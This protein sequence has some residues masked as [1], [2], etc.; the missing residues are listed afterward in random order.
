M[1][2]VIKMGVVDVDVRILGHLKEELATLGPQINCFGLLVLY[3]DLKNRK[4]T[5]RN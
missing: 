1:A 4:N 2:S 5:K 3:S